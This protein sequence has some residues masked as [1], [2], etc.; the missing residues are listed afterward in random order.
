MG[1]TEGFW[2]GPELQRGALTVGSTHARTAICWSCLQ[3][4]LLVW[5]CSVL[6]LG[7]GA[8]WDLPVGVRQP[9]TLVLHHHR[10]EEATVTDG[11]QSQSSALSLGPRTRTAITGV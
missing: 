7:T 2:E 5:V 10:E 1:A 11:S 8:P 4:C 9:L 6:G 3:V